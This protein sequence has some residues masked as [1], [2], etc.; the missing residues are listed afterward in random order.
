MLGPKPAVDT[1][2]RTGNTRVD[3][4]FLVPGEIRKPARIRLDLRLHI[5]Q[6]AHVEPSAAR[7]ENP[8]IVRFAANDRVLSEEIAARRSP[9]VVIDG[10]HKVAITFERDQISYI[11]P[12]VGIVLYE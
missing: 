8:K 3:S 4:D 12:I 5:Q 7:F 9:V 11:S 1:H 2:R 10:N 6:R